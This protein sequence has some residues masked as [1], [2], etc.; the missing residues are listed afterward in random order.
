MLVN[1]GRVICGT[2]GREGRPTILP[3]YCRQAEFKEVVEWVVK[4]WYRSGKERKQVSKIAESE[5]GCRSKPSKGVDK[6]R[7]TATIE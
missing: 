2:R 1:S 5:R 3:G 7:A 4:Y 6:R